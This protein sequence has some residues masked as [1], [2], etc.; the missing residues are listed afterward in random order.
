[1]F[2]E[3]IKTIEILEST[4]YSGFLFM[5]SNKF[6]KRW[7]EF[8]Q[9]FLTKGQELVDLGEKIE[10]QPY[11]KI[12]AEVEKARVQIENAKIEPEKKH[13]QKV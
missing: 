2:S 11:E 3:K 9:P 5:R 6:V 10:R 8:L 7:F 1:M 12:V 13:I 4:S